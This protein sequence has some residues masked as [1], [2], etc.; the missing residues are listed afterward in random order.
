MT[1]NDRDNLD[2]PERA[3]VA[4]LKHVQAQYG[5]DLPDSLWR[6]IETGQVSARDL[7]SQLVEMENNRRRRYGL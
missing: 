5:V 4:V 1:Y 6:D 7:V 3:A 2:D